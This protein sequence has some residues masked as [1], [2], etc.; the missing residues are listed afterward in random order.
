MEISS[1]QSPKNM[2][3]LSTGQRMKSYLED[4][5]NSDDQILLLDEWDANLDPFNFK[6]IEKLIE[7]ISRTKKIIQVRHLKDVFIDKELK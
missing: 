7:Q 1:E 2:E 6:R 4:L 3:S 5:I